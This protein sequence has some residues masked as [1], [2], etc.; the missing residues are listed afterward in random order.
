MEVIEDIGDKA[1]WFDDG[2]GGQ[3]TI[4]QGSFRLIV[5]ASETDTNTSLINQKL[6]ANSHAYDVFAGCLY[7]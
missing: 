3:L 4:F 6:L 7:W 5:N 2:L 1:G